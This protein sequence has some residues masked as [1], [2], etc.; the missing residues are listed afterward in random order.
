MARDASGDLGL[1]RPTSGLESTQ[2]VDLCAPCH[3]RRAEVSDYDHVGDEFLDVALPALL[4]EGLYHPDGQILD[5]VYVY[6]SF[7]Q[8][9]M[10]ANGVRCSDC[11][12]SHSL[13]LVREGNALCGQC[14]ELAV[15]D[16]PAHHF[17]KLEVEGRPSDGAQC[18][19][20]HMVEQPYMVIDWRA[21][22]SFRLP[23]PDLS[24][25]IGTPNA[26]TQS[27]CHDDRPLQW[28][29]D[30]WNRWYGE[31]RRP[32]FGTVFAAARQGDTAGLADLVRSPL[33]PA[34]VRATALD[35]LAFNGGEEVGTLCADLLL[36]EESILRQTAVTNLPLREPET[37]AR[38]VAP[39]LADPVKAVRLAAS[40]RLAGVDP[41][42]LAEYQLA[43]LETGLAEYRTTMLANLDFAPAAMNL[44]ALAGRLGDTTEAERYLTQALTVDDRFTPARANL[45]IVLASAGRD[46]AAVRL[47]EE[48]VAL[49]PD[50]SE[51]WRMLG[52]M[53]AGPPVPARGVAPLRRAIELNRRDARAR[54]NLGLLLDQLG[55][56][57]GAEA[58]LA[59]A[60]DLVPRSPDFLYALAEHYLRRGMFD[61]VLPLAD[62][63]T[64][65]LPDQPVGAQLRQAAERGN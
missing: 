51:L 36:A 52:L 19:K 28:S 57:E 63:L 64:E 7:V 33:Q 22:H 48:G 41:A 10:Y 23:R 46:S 14:H 39:L 1:A 35:L 34:L 24:A 58:Q 45:A 54:Y 21:D 20:C 13:K 3:S 31:A 61:A 50:E 12:D 37:F 8:S 53:Y 42:L 60:L 29:L 4:R 59:A 49:T 27:G 38:R 25:S 62:R 26:C 55:D 9:K 65:V 30:A 18:V 5:E 44:G 17:H 15:Y 11:H 56:P 47:L 43:D 32:H 16:T 40:S 2:L 6:G